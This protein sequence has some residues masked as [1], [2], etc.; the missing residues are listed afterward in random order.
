MN[1]VLLETIRSL[2][3]SP[4][5]ASAD[6]AAWARLEAELDSDAAEVVSSG[7]DAHCYMAKLSA[8]HKEVLQLRFYEDLSHDEI[9]VRLG[10]SNGYARLRLYRALNAAK[11]IAGAGMREDRQ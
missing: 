3:G 1:L 10:I 5:Q 9:A 11:L 8:E 6:P 4:S 2:F 7:L